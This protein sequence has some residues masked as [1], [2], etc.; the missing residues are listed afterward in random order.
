MKNF[1]FLMI[2]SL[3]AVF[4]TAQ[5]ATFNW[6]TD[7]IS[8]G[9]NLKGM[10]VSGDTSAIIIGYDNTFKK[11]TDKG[12]SWSDIKAFD[13]E[14][15]F[16]GMSNAEGVTFISSRRPKIVNHPSGGFPD[17]YVSGVLLKSI[18]KGA[19]WDVLDITKFGAGDTASVNPNAAGG[20]G[21]DL[22]AVGALNAD[23]FMVY[24]GWYDISSG[25]KTSRGGVFLTKDGGSNWETIISGLGTNI[26]TSIVF[27]DSIAIIGGSKALHKTNL[28]TNITT[29]IYP[30]LAVGTNSSL[31]A[32]AITMVNPDSFYVTTT[33]D[34]IFSTSDGGNIF[35]KLDG[36]VG[37][38]DLFLLNDSSVIVLGNSTKSKVST[39]NGISWTDCYPGATCWKIGGILGDTLYGLA[40]S[41]AYKI[42]VED[43]VAKN[44][45]WNTVT[46]NDG[47][48]LQKMAIYD[49]NNAI[50]GTYGEVCKKTT[51][52]GLTWTSSTL[53]TDYEEDVEFGFNSISANGANAFSA[54]R[55]FKIADFPSDGPVSDFYMEGL[56][57]ST[58]D[59]WETVNLL[60]ASKV[61]IDDGDDVT[62]NPQ[63]EGCYGLNPYTIYCVDENTAYLYANWYETVTEGA[64]KSRG[65]VFKTTDGG[66]SWYA[67]TKDFEGSYITGIEFINDTGY[68]A[69][70][71]I[72]LKTIDGGTTFT[73]LYP[74][75]A[76]S[77][78]DST[79]YLN[80]VE[81]INANEFYI[82]TISDGVFST[83]DGGESFTKF[84]GVAGT[85]D[86]FKF[87]QNSF[88]CMG[89]TTKSHFTNDGG[90]NWQNASA[91]T[92]IYSIGEVLNDSLY[93]LGKGQIVKIALSDLD[94]TTSILEIA[95]GNKIDIQYHP[96]FI[97]VISSEKNIDRFYVYSITGK[98]VSI[99][100]PNNRT[101]LLN[102]NEYNSGIYIVAATVAGE[103]FARKIVFN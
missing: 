61:G 82:P 35:T 17:V 27:K 5:Q 67:V 19:T 34:G 75:L 74:I 41:V 72:L 56:I 58:N 77:N 37:G 86:F 43:L 49:E 50:I 1:T 7:T 68:I 73:D 63:L 69:G 100:E 53:P 88:I 95:S 102:K 2:F 87:D 91:G 13:P 59:N 10:T 40:K 64:A 20:Y 81:L 30:N 101:Y 45:N 47:E 79:I 55:R 14:F 32:S 71:N 38:N 80:N 96:D 62:K 92:T 9:N 93:A 70:K 57:L 54:I 48:N 60:D 65:R 8:E 23:T 99:A 90:I 51:D 85:N 44:F 42:A 31:Y 12:L 33:L 78:A 36:I 24:S 83:I 22:Y 103:R 11:S 89:S 15:D 46:I 94:L 25:T 76:A 16:I 52:G 4:A 21:K 18:D 3:L 26:I 97:Q 6:V 39:D 98:L 66:D 84:E 29:D 28:N